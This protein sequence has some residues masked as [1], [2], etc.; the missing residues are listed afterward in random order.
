MK[1][2][3]FVSAIIVS[4]FSCSKKDDEN[5][6]ELN[7]TNV[8]GSYKTTTI[9]YKANASAPEQDFYNYFNSDVCDR[10]DYVTYN[11]DGT[12]KIVD[13]GEVCFPSNNAIG[14]WS[15]TGNTL[16]MDNSASTVESFDCKTL[17][18]K[19]VNVFVSGDMLYVTSVRQ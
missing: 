12:Y 5:T 6:C 9:K 11:T 2:L 4:L 3:L 16:T 8:A 15:L 18:V 13:A 19:A 1:R 17:T 14:T 10:D 7:A